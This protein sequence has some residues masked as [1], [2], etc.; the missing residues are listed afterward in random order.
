M[1]QLLI[2]DLNGVLCCKTTRASKLTVIAKTRHYNV[3]LRPHVQEFLREMFSLYQVAFFTSTTSGNAEQVLRNLLTKSQARKSFFK[4]SRDRTRE[5]LVVS[6]EDPFPTLKMLEDVFELPKVK[7]GGY[8]Y[9][10]T[11]ICDDSEAKLRYNPEKNVL[12]CEAFLGD[13][14]DSYLKD[15]IHYI[16]EK[17]MNM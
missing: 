12:V 17:F 15:L 6:S 4:W 5:D 14:D 3:V 8:N 16:A 10:N 11:L 1:T 7:L 9:T 13:P 2:L